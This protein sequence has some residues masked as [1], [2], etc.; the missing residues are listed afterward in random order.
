MNKEKAK[1]RLD[2]LENEA[3]ELRKIIEGSM[4]DWVFE[5][6]DTNYI[7]DSDGEFWASADNDN[8]YRIK[9]VNQLKTKEYCIQ[10]ARSNAWNSLLFKLA[11]HF[12][13]DGWEWVVGEKYYLVS[14]GKD[15]SELRI[16]CKLIYD[17][18]TAKFHPD[19]I[20]DVLVE[21]NNNK[22]KWWHLVTDEELVE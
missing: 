19:V 22:S 7:A 6:E 9:Y 14:F 5:D 18:M 16:V 21:L 15:N 4:F 10:S 2:A 17:F 20:T 1:Q 8:R 11:E 13:P 12:N 3:R